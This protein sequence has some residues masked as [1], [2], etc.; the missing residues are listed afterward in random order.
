VEIQ[1]RYD[2]G[3]TVCNVLADA[4][5]PQLKPLDARDLTG[6]QATT[7]GRVASV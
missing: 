5:V 2:H 6:S 4:K 3:A 1:A 7:D